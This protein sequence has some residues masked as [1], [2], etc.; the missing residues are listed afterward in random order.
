MGGEA[1]DKDD[2]DQALDSLEAELFDDISDE[3]DELEHVEGVEDVQNVESVESVERVEEVADLEEGPAAPS[4]PPKLPRRPTGSTRRIAFDELFV[5]DTAPALVGGTPDQKIEYLRNKLRHAETIIA[6]VREAWEMRETEM[7]DFEATAAEARKHA[8]QAVQQRVALEQFFE[9][10]K[11][12][13]TDYINKVTRAFAEKDETERSLRAQ[14]DQARA[15]NRARTEELGAAQDGLRAD[16]DEARAEVE[17]AC[18]RADEAHQELAD[19]RD[20]LH[21][22]IELRDEAIAKLKKLVEDQ[23]GA[24]AE[25]DAALE[26]QMDATAEQERQAARALAEKQKL[27]RALSSRA[28]QA[29][30]EHA[31][32]E[33]VRVALEQDIAERDDTIERLKVGLAEVQKTLRERDHDVEE[34]RT[35]LA[36]AGE[37]AA[38]MENDKA[39]LERQ[40]RAE[41]DTL[42]LSIEADRDAASVSRSH[43]AAQTETIGRLK[44]MLEEHQRRVTERDLRIE[45]LETE[46]AEAKREALRAQ[47]QAMRQAAPGAPVDGARGARLQKALHL[48]DRLFFDLESGHP[49]LFDATQ[50]T[51]EMLARLRKAVALARKAAEML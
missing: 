21:H 31:A 46:V 27:E 37:N 50:S 22:D 10:K 3:L 16:L 49:D 17:A 12:E 40:L 35:E 29:Q 47:E 2:V 38:K 24:I 32:L 39:S 11:A 7:D 9:S 4:G 23:R 26:E 20:A 33:Q 45:T 43:D 30:D 13:F 44:E 25:R 36:L 18:A 28:A 8:E 34:L 19:T 51:G 6:R 15:D 1:P 5:A 41:I 48:A 42:T 14:L